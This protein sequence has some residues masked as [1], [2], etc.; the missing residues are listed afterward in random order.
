MHIRFTKPKSVPVL[1]CVRDDGSTT[2]AKSAHGAYFGYHDLLHYAVENTLGFRDAFFG[3]IA[4]GRS[5]QSF[6][7]PGAARTLPAEAIIADHI[8]GL[9][10]QE[11]ATGA[12]ADAD[13][14]NRTLAVCLGQSGIVPARQISADELRRIRESWAVLVHRYRSLGPDGAIELQFP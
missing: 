4:Q 1:T 6:A 11:A 5:I 9:L 8:V 7:E 12:A 14:F 10:Q 3:L 2:Y 13:E